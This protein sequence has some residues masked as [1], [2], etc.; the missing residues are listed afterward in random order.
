VVQE[1]DIVVDIGTGLGILAISA[2]RAGAQHVYAVEASGIGKSAKAIFEANGV[3][4]RVTLIEGWSTQIDLPEQAD[5][6][7]S[8]IIGHEP[9]GERV[10]EITMDAS[11]RLLKPNARLIPHKIRILGLPVTIPQEELMKQTFTAQTL[12]NWQS[13][14]GIDFSVLEE[15]FRNTTNVFFINS[16]SARDWKTISEPLLLAEVDLKNLNDLII[17][18]TILFTANTS[19]TLNGL[20]EYFGLELGPTARFS[21]YPTQ[22]DE[23]NHWDSPVWIFSDPFSVEPGDKFTVTYQYR[24]T[25]DRTKVSVSRL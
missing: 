3:A 5:V 17:D 18:K 25:E 6:L 24:K 4:D 10:L 15:T 8:E 13:W 16:F 23:A 14:Y 11:K 20:V 22:V 1:G 7:I 9:L 2:V 21:T 19:G 12:Q